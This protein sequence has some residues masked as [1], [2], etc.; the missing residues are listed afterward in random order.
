[1]NRRPTAYEGVEGR[2][3]NMLLRL[4][5][6]RCGRGR[7]RAAC[8]TAPEGKT[9]LCVASPPEKSRSCAPTDS[10]DQSGFGGRPG[11]RLRA[12]PPLGLRTR[13][14]SP[15]QV[16]LQRLANDRRRAANPKPLGGVVAPPPSSQTHLYPSA[17][18]HFASSDP[19]HAHPSQ[20]KFSRQP[21]LCRTSNVASRLPDQRSIRSTTTQTVHPSTVSPF[22]WG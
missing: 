12:S 19:R 3:N 10:V 21:H 7:H 2:R 15:A 13:E 8:V 14:E 18:H 5:A 9:A 11:R 20:K 16:I 6:A 1:L 4:D 17:L 22:G